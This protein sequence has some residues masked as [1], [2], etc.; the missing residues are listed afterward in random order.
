MTHSEH[1]RL[2]EALGRLD[3]EPERMRRMEEAALS[4]FD[5]HQQ[6]LTA[7]WI[8]LLRARPAVHGGL[9]LAAAAALVLVSPI[10]AAL[11]WLL[12]G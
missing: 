2:D 5:A 11:L 8:G 4:A 10:G 1:T 6:G 9:A 12:G 7:E 3:P